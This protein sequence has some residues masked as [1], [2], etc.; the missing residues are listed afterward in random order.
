MMI[1]NFC[2]FCLGFFLEGNGRDGCGSE[3]GLF[4]DVFE[5]VDVFFLG[6]IVFMGGVVE[7]GVEVVVVVVFLLLFCIFILDGLINLVVNS[8]FFWGG[9]WRLYNV[10]WVVVVFLID[11]YWIGIDVIY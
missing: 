10:L 7:V 9:Y 6:V 5:L 1:Y 4:V 3:V 2:L 8:C 11:E